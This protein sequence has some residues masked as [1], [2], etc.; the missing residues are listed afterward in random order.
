MDMRMQ[1]PKPLCFS[2][3]FNDISIHPARKFEL[4]NHIRGIAGRYKIPQGMT[5]KQYEEKHRLLMQETLL[6]SVPNKDIAPHIL[7]QETR[8][9]Q[10][11]AF[12]QESWDRLVKLNPILK[13]IKMNSDNTRDLYNAH[14]GVTSG[15][16]TDDINF[17]IERDNDGGQ[18]AKQAREMPVHGDMLKRINAV[19]A[20][21]LNW[22]PS[23]QTAQKIEAGFKRRGML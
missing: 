11:P 21:H 3:A 10:P 2:K 1:A 8:T 23:P 16:N 19:S 14:M 5:A 7:W 4:F 22:V 6:T 9:I 13:T 15:F 18:A 17:Y 12:L 20:T